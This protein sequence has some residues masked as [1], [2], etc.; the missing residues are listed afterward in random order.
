MAKGHMAIG[1]L[2]RIAGCKVE[3]VRYYE[4]AKLMHPPER[5]PAGQRRYTEIDAKRLSF[6]RR[7]RNLG[8]SIE[9][10]RGLLAMVDDQEHS[11]DSVR[12][13]ALSHLQNVQQRLAD[14]RT[15]ESVLGDMISEC[16]GGT[17]PDCP[18]LDALF[19]DHP[20][21]NRAPSI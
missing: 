19:S 5:S 14:L 1:A 20:E 15:M 11:C 21:D 16:A 17:V 9:E 2:A 10:V 18:I 6:I 8:F 13:T 3:T 7:A 4:L 12:A